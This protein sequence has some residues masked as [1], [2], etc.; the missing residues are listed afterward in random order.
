M[1]RTVRRCL[2]ASTALAVVAVAGVASAATS[3]AAPKPLGSTSLVQVLMADGD[4]FDS[5]WDDY[6]ILTQAVVAVLKAKPD[7]AVKVLADGN[8]P[9]TAFL[10]TDRAFQELAKSLT[11]KTYYQESGVFKALATTA[12]IDAIEAVLLYH[13]IPGAT[14][15][16]AD[17]LAKRSTTVNTA[18]PG[19]SLTI[20]TISAPYGV[21]RLRDLDTNSRDAFLVGSQLDI[22]KGNKQIAHGI[23]AVMRPLDLP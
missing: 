9:V 22:N 21:V 1:S 4:T 2:T 18:L 3:S 19:A 10:P 11:G 12:G 20:A 15:T 6:D 16:S 8:T 13:V 17:V 14:V 5:N 23:T 7:S